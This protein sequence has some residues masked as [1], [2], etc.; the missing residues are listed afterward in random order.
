[1]KANRITIGWVLFAFVLVIL[2]AVLIIPAFLAGPARG[3]SSAARSTPGRFSPSPSSAAP[4]A[5][6]SSTFPADDLARDSLP[7][8]IL[9]VVI[10]KGSDYE[11]GFRRIRNSFFCCPG[12]MSIHAPTLPHPIVWNDKMGRYHVG[13]TDSMKG[14]MKGS[15]RR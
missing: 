2:A 14:R 11:M 15:D 9:P 8:S 6:L 5:F 7:P 4:A 10:L 3:P 13:A 1:M 12:K